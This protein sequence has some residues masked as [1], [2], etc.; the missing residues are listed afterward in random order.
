MK[1]LLDI[2]DNMALHFMAVLKSIP[3][4]KTELISSENAQ[5]VRELKRAFKELNDFKKGKIKP[6]NAKDF[7]NEL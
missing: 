1:V 4:L 5:F 6:R 3:Y 2:D 7:L